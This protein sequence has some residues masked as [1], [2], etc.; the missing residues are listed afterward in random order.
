ML[1]QS[2][3]LRLQEISLKLVKLF[4]T[5]RNRKDKLDRSQELE[6]ETTLKNLAT[7]TGIT[8]TPRIWCK[9][10]NYSFNFREIRDQVKSFEQNDKKEFLKFMAQ[11]KALV[12]YAAEDDLDGFQKVFAQTCEEK[13]RRN[14]MYWHVQRAFKEAVKYKSLQIVEHV[15]EDLD[16]DLR[17]E[18][19][20]N[21]LHMVLFTAS[22]AE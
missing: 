9:Q 20:K 18:S 8:L 15:I 1:K 4:P 12:E 17:H 6:S 11:G 14:I 7:N 5:N 21:L 19:F 16:L 10:Y 2:E 3:L 22:M 13:S